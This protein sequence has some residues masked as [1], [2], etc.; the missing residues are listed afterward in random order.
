MRESRVAVRQSTV[1]IHAVREQLL[2][3]DEEK[4]NAHH[5]L[6]RCRSRTIMTFNGYTMDIYSLKQRSA[7][8]AKVQRADTRPEVRVRSILHRM[9][10]RFR[11]H[12]R[13]LPGTPDI[14]LPR[15]GTVIF[16]HGCFWHRHSH[17]RKATTPA[18]NAAF[19]SAKF[20][21]NRVRDRRKTR[22]LRKEGWKV[23]VVW[24]CQT[25]KPALARA[26]LNLLSK[27]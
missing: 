12:D 20:K 3:S 15:L 5:A 14:V 23:I 25:K 26:L 4:D 18:N 13:R 21:A 2:C 11:L 19:W 22:C 7:L 24:E 6:E 8:M 9:G 16:V 17:C 1:R 10:F 27:E